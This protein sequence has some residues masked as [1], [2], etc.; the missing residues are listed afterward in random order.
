M[1]REIA[2][3]KQNNKYL[4]DSMVTLQNVIQSNGLDPNPAKYS[5]LVVPPEVDGEIVRIDPSN[6][7]F[8]I[9]IG[10]DDG[11]VA[12]HELFV[13]RLSPQPE[14]LGKV[15]VQTVDSDQAVVTVIG[16]TPQGK[17]IRE[18]DIVSTKIG[19]RG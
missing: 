19:P 12:G 18:G 6:K 10:S 5:Q 17:K 8:Q 11:L 9:S 2:V 14:F 3:A 4:R 13:Y 15:K 16:T 1:R 7:R